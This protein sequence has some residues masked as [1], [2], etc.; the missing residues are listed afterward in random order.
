MAGLT[1]REKK[2]LTKLKAKAVSGDDPIHILNLSNFASDMN[3]KYGSGTVDDP[4]DVYNKGGVV[5]SNKG[6]RDFRKGGMV[7]STVDNR[8]KK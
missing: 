6:S 5:K 2:R 4:A 8:K 7:I 3:Q 1:S